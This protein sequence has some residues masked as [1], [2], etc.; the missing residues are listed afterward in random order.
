MIKKNNTIRLAQWFITAKH[1]N[2]QQFT[3]IFFTAE[4][5]KCEELIQLSNYELL[6]LGNISLKD[7]QII[8]KMAAEKYFKRRFQSG[9]IHF[10]WN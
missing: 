5:T 9:K 2:K 1:S 3:V 10:K 7:V 8:Y 4:V 6:K